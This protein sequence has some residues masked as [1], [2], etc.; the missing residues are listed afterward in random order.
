MVQKHALKIIL[1][2]KTYNDILEHFNLQTLF[3]R[4]DEMCSKLFTNVINNPTHKLYNLLPPKYESVYQR[5]NKEDTTR[6]REDMNIIF[7]W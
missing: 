4:R 2:T 5:F 3:Q 7:E 1:P 6:W